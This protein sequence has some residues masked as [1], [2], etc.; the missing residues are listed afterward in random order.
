MIRLKQNRYLA[1]RCISI[2]ESLLNIEESLKRRRKAILNEAETRG[3]ETVVFI[4]EI[5]D[6][7]PSNFIYVSP[8]GLGDEQQSLVLNVR[9]DVIL[10]TPHWG[11]KKAEESGKYTKVIAIR[12]EKIHHMRGTAVALSGYNPGKVCFDLSTMSA[13]FSYSLAEVL[14]MQ[15]NEKKDISSFIFTLRSIKDIYEVEEIS[16]A[17]ELTE[18][19]F[20]ELYSSAKPGKDLWTLKKTLD[21]RMIEL[22]AIDR[23]F[24]SSLSLC[25]GSRSPSGEVRNGDMLSVDVGCRL[26]NG[27]CSDMGRTW[28]VGTPKPEEQ[29]FLERIAEAQ[30]EGFKNITEGVSG[31]EVLRK[32]NTIN[33]RLD[34]APALRCGHQIGLECHDY[35]MPYAPNFGTIE[36]DALKLKAGMTLTYEPTR[37]DTKLALRSHIEDIILITK[38][39]PE[40]LNKAP[41]LL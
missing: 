11:A 18:K 26:P 13:Q 28:S 3:F 5:V 37:I 40:V 38:G 7:N 16:K 17:V 31:N 32:A 30:T 35:T 8:E 39:A 23:S 22:G 10:V 27:Y 2:D 36:A 1:R 25:N 20:W 21:A 34:F 15:I 4:N 6:Q 24:D 19:A 14:H 12:Q 29:K 33:Q 9:G 41:W